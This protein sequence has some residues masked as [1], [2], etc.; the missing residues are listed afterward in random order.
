MPTKAHQNLIRFMIDILKK[1]A[2][3]KVK[4]VE[5]AKNLQ[6]IERLQ[7]KPFF[8]RDCFSARAAIQSNDFGIIAEFKRSSPSKPNINLTA[9]PQDIIPAYVQQGAAVV[10]V[11]TDEHFFNGSLDFLTISRHVNAPLLRKDFII[12]PYQ[13]YEAKANGADLIL[14]IAALLGKSQIEAYTKLAHDLG[15]E[16]LLE[17]HAGEDFDKYYSAVDLVG[18]NNR[19]LR[20]F[21]VDIHHSIKMRQILKHDICI[22]ESGI[23]SVETYLKLQKNGFNGFLMGEYFMKHDEPAE[24]LAQFISQI[25]THES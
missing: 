19:N 24:A 17:F 22:A 16:V 8:S 18:I 9:R 25:R 11:L 7:K 15:M 23:H 1:I 2:A 12:D 4:E 20:T 5:K 21:E 10:S 14:L 6:A 3:H 13:I